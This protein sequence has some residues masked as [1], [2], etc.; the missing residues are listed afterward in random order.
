MGADDEWTVMINVTHAA[1]MLSTSTVNTVRAPPH[2]EN[3][4]LPGWWLP[5]LTAPA[6]RASRS[7]TLA[8]PAQQWQWWHKTYLA[9]SLC[10]AL[11]VLIIK[12]QLTLTAKVFSLKMSLTLMMGPYD[13]LAM[14]PMICGHRGTVISLSLLNCNICP[15]H[16]LW[17]VLR[18]GLQYLETVLSRKFAVWELRQKDRDKSCRSPLRVWRLAGVLWRQL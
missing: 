5:P 4:P 12:A 11:I 6:L 13:P 10:G 9:C 17:A 7:L 2:H 14:R 18:C 8:E 16:Q 1:P 3:D 15:N